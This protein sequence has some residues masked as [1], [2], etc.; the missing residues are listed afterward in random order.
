MAILEVL[1][2]SETIR[3]QILHNVSAKT[4]RDLA[5][6]EGMKTLQMAGLNK[7]KLGLTSLDEVLRVTG[8]R[9]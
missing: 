8:G 6:R 1:S 3:E 4:I 5:L 9:G 7:A 2:I